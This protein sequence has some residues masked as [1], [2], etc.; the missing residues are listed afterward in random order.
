VGACAVWFHLAMLG[1]KRKCVRVAKHHLFG[2]SLKGASFL[3][4]HFGQADA[5]GICCRVTHGF[6]S[7]LCKWL[8]CG[9]SHRHALA[10]AHASGG[11]KCKRR[12]PY[13][14]NEVERAERSVGLHK[15]ERGRLGCLLRAPEAEPLRGFGG[16]FWG[17]C[18]GAGTGRYET[19]FRTTRMY[20]MSPLLASAVRVR[21][22]LG[23]PG[24]P[25]CLIR[26]IVSASRKRH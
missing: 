20:P 11:G 5:V 19:Q 24:I 14:R 6:S 1:T 8:G 7:S 18:C 12:V 23:S 17:G 21:L 9:C 3:F 16:C 22:R 26:N 2:H 10:L 25:A 4:Q 15:R 13:P